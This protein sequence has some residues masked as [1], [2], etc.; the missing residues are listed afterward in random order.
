MSALKNIPPPPV[1]LAFCHTAAE[2]YRG[3]LIRPPFFFLVILMVQTWAAQINLNFNP[4][5]V[6]Q[7]GSSAQELSQTMQM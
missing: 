6:K 1:S 5:A 7:L 3:I 2:L 4:T